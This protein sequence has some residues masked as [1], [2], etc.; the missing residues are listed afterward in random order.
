MEMVPRS[1]DILMFVCLKVDNEVTLQISIAL[2]CCTETI[3][4]INGDL[5]RHSIV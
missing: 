1:H 4:T 2:C 3:S 5:L